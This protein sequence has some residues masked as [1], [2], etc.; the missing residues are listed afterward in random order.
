MRDVLR[1]QVVERLGDPGGVLVV[2]DTGFEKRGRR[3]AGVQRQ[4]IGTAC[5]ITNCRIGVF[6]FY[7]SPDNQRVIIDRELRVFL[8]R[9]SGS[10]RRPRYRR[11]RTI[12]DQAELV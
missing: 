5:K 11:A 8:V 2:D 12:C 3:S 10:A 7:V 9:R 1:E 4:H 6:Y